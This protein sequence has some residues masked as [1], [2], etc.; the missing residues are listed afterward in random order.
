VVRK[1]LH[2][3]KTIFLPYYHVFNIVGTL[4]LGQFVELVGLGS[5]LLVADRLLGDVPALVDASLSISVLFDGILNNE[6]LQFLLE[7]ANM[8]HPVFRWHNLH[9][10][11]T[12]KESTDFSERISVEVVTVT[13]TMP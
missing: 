11:T 5:E 1:K 2:F 3:S 13:L 10:R 8:R 6:L 7:I 9:K 4:A 12:K